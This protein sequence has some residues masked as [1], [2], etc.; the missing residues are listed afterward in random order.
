[1]PKGK[2]EVEGSEAVMVTE[3]DGSTSLVIRSVTD[4][5]LNAVASFEDAVRLATEVYGD[6]VPSYELGDGFTAVDSKDD[7]VGVP[8]LIIGW[9]LGWSDF[10]VGE[11]FSIVRVVTQDNQKLRFVDGSTGV[12]RQLMDSFRGSP[13]NFRAILAIDGL[14]RNEYTPRDENGDVLTDGKGNPIN[15][16]VTYRI[17][18]DKLTVASVK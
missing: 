4:A 6:L 2:V 11:R 5:E 15:K 9:G 16:A 13:V 14:Q 12:H 7:L 8:F 3:G 1:M 17:N 18:S 10:G